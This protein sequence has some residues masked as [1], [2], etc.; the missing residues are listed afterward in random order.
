MGHLQVNGNS[1]DEN[2]KQSMMI[3]EARS[4]ILIA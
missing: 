2:V 1:F 3:V 4:M